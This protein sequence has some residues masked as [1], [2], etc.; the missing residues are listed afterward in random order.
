MKLRNTTE[1]I[2]RIKLSAGITTPGNKRYV[3]LGQTVSSVEST[4]ENECKEI[5]YEE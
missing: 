3:F 1:W 4:D 2:F 5:L